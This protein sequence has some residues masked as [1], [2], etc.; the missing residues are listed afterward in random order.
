M[1]TEIWISLLEIRACRTSSMLT[2]VAT[3]RA[4][5]L[6]PEYGNTNS[7]AWGDWDGDGDFYLAVGID[8]GALTYKRRWHT[9]GLVFTRR[10]LQQRSLGRLGW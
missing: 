2:Q 3:F 5:M 7:V 9:V 6:L 1:V 4:L 10:G 8:S